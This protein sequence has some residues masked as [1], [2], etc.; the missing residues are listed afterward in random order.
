MSNC[1]SSIC[2]HRD[3]RTIAILAPSRHSHPVEDASLPNKA[4]S[5]VFLRNYSFW[6][7][8]DSSRNHKKRVEHQRR[9]AGAGDVDNDDGDGEDNDDDDVDDVADD[10]DEDDGDEDD[11]DD[12]DDVDDG[13]R[14]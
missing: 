10:D 5:F 12:D 11:D 2:F 8:F 7:Y 3:I 9:A 1:P 14:R 6:Y 4:C 13:T